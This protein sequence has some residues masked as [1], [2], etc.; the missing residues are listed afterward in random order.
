ME[1]FHDGILGTGSG[2]K[3]VKRSC[4]VSVGDDAQSMPFR[5]KS[6]RRS[7]RKASEKYDSADLMDRHIAGCNV[8]ALR[9]TDNES[10][11]RNQDQETTT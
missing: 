9:L 6:G 2:K 1:I 4:R 3:A 10:G 7:V 5:Y 11:I 8:K